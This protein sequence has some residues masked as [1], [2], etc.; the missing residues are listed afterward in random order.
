MDLSE[1]LFERKNLPKIEKFG[2]KVVDEFII[3][4]PGSWALKGTP[5]IGATLECQARK[6]LG[7]RKIASIGHFCAFSDHSNTLSQG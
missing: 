4:V 1:Y 2:L 3:V 5:K 6:F 7:F